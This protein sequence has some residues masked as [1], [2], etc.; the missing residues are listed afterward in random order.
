MLIRRHFRIKILQFI[1]AQYLSKMDSKKVEN[2]ILYSIDELH[3]L[4]ISLLCLILQMQQLA[5]IT[6]QEN[7]I[8]LNNKIIQQ[9]AY[10]SIINILSHNKYIIEYNSKK[11]WKYFLW[12]K[13]EYYINILLQDLIQLNDD[14]MFI[15]NNNVSYFQKDKHFII[16]CYKQFFFTNK[17][18]IEYIED[19]YHTYTICTKLDL[20]IAHQMVYKT[21][22]YIELYT[23]NNFKLIDISQN[24]QQFIINLYRNT[25]NHKNEL[26]NL[27]E[28]ISTNWTIKRIYI[29]DLI[30]LQMAICEF[31]YFPHIPPKA[32]IN[33][34][35]EITK[36]FCMEKS[37]IFVNGILDKILQLLNK[38]NNLKKEIHQKS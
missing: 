8:L 31:L 27:I 16:T 30:I 34:Y 5:I 15:N 23:P 38:E 10:N 22:K 33:E 13:D 17:K 9:F 2:N 37:K 21:L 35:I 6:I 19:S 24:N 7:K 11:Y 25:I 14:N 18:L 3:Y 36:L 20:F 4:Y 12:Q 1:Y 28:R 26:N 29:I 32:T